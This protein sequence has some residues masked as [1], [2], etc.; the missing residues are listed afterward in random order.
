MPYSDEAGVKTVKLNNAP[1]QMFIPEQQFSY[2]YTRIAPDNPGNIFLAGN[3]MAYDPAVSGINGWRLL[4]VAEGDESVNGVKYEGT[5]ATGTMRALNVRDIYR[6]FGDKM[7]PGV[8]FLRV[9][10]HGAPTSPKQETIK[11]ILN[12]AAN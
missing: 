3:V 11:I 9:Y 5:V 8:L 2:V 7:P 10:L 6:R 1:F 12:Q 4:A